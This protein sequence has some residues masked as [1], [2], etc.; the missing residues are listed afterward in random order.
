MHGVVRFLPFVYPG[1]H[2]THRFWDSLGVSEAEWLQ[3]QV[4]SGEENALQTVRKHNISCSEEAAKQLA[5]MKDPFEKNV[6]GLLFV[7]F[8]YSYLFVF[9]LKGAHL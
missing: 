7:V 1:R 9:L 8:Y 3:Q 2:W 4:L 6:K 5:S